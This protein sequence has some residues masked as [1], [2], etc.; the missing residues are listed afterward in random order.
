MI[1]ALIVVGA[2]TVLI[3]LHYDRMALGVVIMYFS[4]AMLIKMN[5]IKQ[6]TM[7]LMMIKQIN[8]MLMITAMIKPH[9]EIVQ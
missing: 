5:V 3:T 7:T 8:M 1:P 9:E 6:R 2:S 4:L